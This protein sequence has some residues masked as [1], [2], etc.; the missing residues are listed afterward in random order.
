[1]AT[2]YNTVN[3]LAK[4]GLIQSLPF[5]DGARYDANPDPHANLV[6]VQCQRIIDAVDNDAIVSRLRE[7]L[8][9]RNGFQVISQRLDFYGYCPDCAA[10]QTQQASRHEQSA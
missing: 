7:E 9:G 2:V 10:A 1:M 8:T 6:C 5:P 4:S 3:T